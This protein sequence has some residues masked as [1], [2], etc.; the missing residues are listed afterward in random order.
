M[1]SL[2]VQIKGKSIEVKSLK[3]KVAKIKVR[4]KHIKI[5]ETSKDTHCS[6]YPKSP[7]NKVSLLRKP[8]FLR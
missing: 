1:N 5:D 2:V 4:R 8:L 3:M 7:L 6:C